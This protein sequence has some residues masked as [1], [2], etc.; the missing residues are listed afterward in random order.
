MYGH[1]VLVG[2]VEGHLDDLAVAFAILR[3]A[4]EAQL[5]ALEQRRLGRVA[6]RVALKDGLLQVG[7]VQLELGAV[8]QHGAADES[9]QAGRVLVAGRAHLV[10]GGVDL[11]DVVVVPHVSDGHAILRERAR[12]VGADGGGGAERL[13]GL[14]V[15]D[16]AVL[17]GHA[18]GGEREAHG[19]GGEQTLGHVGHN[20]ADEKDDRVEPVVAEH[21]RDDEERDAEEDGHA[22]D[23]VNEVRYFARNRRLA[24]VQARR[25][26]G[27]AAHD[28]AIAG[29]NH[30]AG[31]RALD[32]VGGEEGD[33]AR[34]ERILVGELGRARLRLGLARQRRVVDLEAVRVQHAYV[35]GHAV[36]EL[37]LDDVALDEVLG[38]DGALVA[39]ADDHRLLG[40][41]VLEG[42]HDARALRLLEVG[43]HAGEKDDHGE[44]HAQ[45]QVVLGRVVVGGLGYAVGDKAQDGAR[46]QEHGEAAEQLLAELDPLGR[47]LGRRQSVGSVALEHLARALLRQTLGLIGAEAREQLVDADLVLVELDL[48]LQLL[49][50]LLLLQLLALLGL[51]GRRGRGRIV[52]AAV[53]VVV[54]VVGGNTVRFLLTCHLITTPNYYPPS[55]NLIYSNRNETKTNNTH[56]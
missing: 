1:L 3:H 51:G 52:A 49:E 8:A 25:E 42:L 21:E 12:L 14:Q 47:R 55:Q 13:D 20:D 38:L 39:V 15:L 7:R 27:Y 35:G 22:R 53:V 11:G 23:Q 56:K 45:P 30:H 32:G 37:D 44:R 50:V 16:E 31:A 19:D 18:L 40:H 41:H 54:V 36:A 48:L 43:E 17:L 46:P 33:V 4:A 9:A 24:R 6:D 29:A 10:F 28:R 2:R 26:V 5:A 34:L